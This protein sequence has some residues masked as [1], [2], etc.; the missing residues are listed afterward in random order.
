[1]PDDAEELVS[2]YEEKQRREAIHS[3]EIWHVRYMSKNA[4]GTPRWPAENGFFH[5]KCYDLLDD[6]EEEYL[7]FIFPREHAKTMK[8]NEEYVVKEAVTKPGSYIIILRESETDAEEN[9]KSIRSELE[10][11]TFIAEDYG[12]QVGK[13]WTD[14]DILLRNGSRVRGA[15]K[16]ASLRGTKTGDQRPTHVLLDDM[17]KLENLDSPLNRDRDWRWVLTTVLPIGTIGT[18]Y[19]IMGNKIHRDSIIARAEKNSAWKTVFYKAW[20]D[21]ART[22]PLW[23]EF[24]TVKRLRA[25][26]VS[27]GKNEF[28]REMMNNPRDAE[29]AVFDEKWFVFEDPPVPI[30]DM[31]RIYAYADPAQGK[32]DSDIS[33]FVI[34]GIWQGITYVLEA[35]MEQKGVIKVIDVGYEFART[36]DMNLVGV[37]SNIYGELLDERLK[38]ER[39][40]RGSTLPWKTYNVYKN[41][42]IRIAKTE[43]PIQAGTLR[44][45]KKLK[46]SVL[47]QQYLDYHAKRG[48]EDDGPDAVAGA[49]SMFP[50][51][52]F[53]SPKVLGDD[54][55]V[56]PA[57]A[58]R[59][60]K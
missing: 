36:I 55:R 32:K 1:M 16:R 43:A 49:F 17:Q 50:R 19:V 24:W 40:E 29:D 58:I 56:Q 13:T 52:G 10:E 25:K 47:I 12:D 51:T 45:A 54:T 8:F 3:Q 28:E 39:E 42:Q 37:E 11:N 14:L 57:I 30:N 21:K 6:P 60:G 22:K 46:E 27:L 53:G 4:D 35:W 18:Q 2:L 23:P 34:L 48:D 31:E 5:Y 9:I 20:L 59:V 38:I 7:V 33:A 26:E 15:G 44:F 41:K